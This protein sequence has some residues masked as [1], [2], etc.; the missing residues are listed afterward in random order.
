MSRD[1]PLRQ[2]HDG[3]VHACGICG[4]AVP[5]ERDQCQRCG[6]PVDEP[7]VVTPDSESD[8]YSAGLD[9]EVR[10]SVRP[11]WLAV[12]A[13]IVVALGATYGRGAVARAEPVASTVKANTS[14]ASHE[15]NSL[16]APDASSASI[17][18]AEAYGRGDAPGAV[19]AYSDAVVADPENAD[20]LNN[21]G[22]SLVRA[23]KARQ[24]LQYFERAIGLNANNWAY[25]FNR[26]RA[27]AELKEWGRAVAGYR[28]ADSLFPNDYATTFNLAKAL[29]ASG[30]A[31]GAI[32]VFESAITLAPGEADFQLSYGLA[33]E[34]AG[35]PGEAVEAYGRYVMAEPDAPNV[36]AVRQRIAAIEAKSR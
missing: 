28:Q 8:A 4:T 21:L 2:G 12:V 23:G 34:S 10:H 6:A 19:Q 20:A 33:L 31:A 13:V 7:V 29:H 5:P 26:A 11:M 3:Q 22:Q 35:R 1:V 36:E 27:H 24:A 17:D 32:R 14:D 18:G 25:H 15:A 30:D 9:D 16:E